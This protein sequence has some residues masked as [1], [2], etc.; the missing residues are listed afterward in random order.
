[1]DKL[2]NKRLDDDLAE[3]I[4]WDELERRCVDMLVEQFDEEKYEEYLEIAK[5]LSDFTGIDIIDIRMLVYN[6]IMNQIKDNL[7]ID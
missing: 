1:M 3:Q 5:K 2:Q 6:R 7:K 4:L